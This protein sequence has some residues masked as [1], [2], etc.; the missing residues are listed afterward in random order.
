[1]HL[2]PEDI[3]AAETCGVSFLPATAAQ[4]QRLAMQRKVFYRAGEPILATRGGGFFETVGTLQQLIEEG[5]QQQR[6]LAGWLQAPPP[7]A[8][9]AAAVL[10]TVPELALPSELATLPEVAVLPGADVASPDNPSPS[11]SPADPLHE[12][13][14]SQAEPAPVPQ[15]PLARETPPKRQRQAK[16]RPEAIKSWTGMAAQPEPVAVLHDGDGVEPAQVEAGPIEDRPVLLEEEATGAAVGPAQQR[17]K[18]WL[19][20]GAARRGRAAKHWSTRQR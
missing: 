15:M 9:G 7:S 19:V 6:D 1:M 8:P 12:A 11:E 16:R 10:P 5:R 20:A 18:R 17:G 2:S 3:A 13:P 4:V 14:E